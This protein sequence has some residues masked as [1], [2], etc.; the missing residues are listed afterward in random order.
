MDRSVGWF[1]HPHAYT[2]NAP[3]TPMRTLTMHQTP[4]CVHSQCTKHPHAYTHN[5]PNT[6]M[7]TLTMHQTPPC[8]QQPQTHV[9][10][11]SNTSSCPHYTTTLPPN[12]TYPP[13]QVYSIPLGGMCTRQAF[14]I[15]GSGSTYIYG[16]VD[17]TYKDKMSSEQ[18]IKFTTNGG[19]CGLEW[20]GMW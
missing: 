10:K 18:C 13:T 9:H 7:R 2:H 5:A 16:Y 11:L 4:P 8:V 19:W 14:T 20:V 6:P 3:N 1:K 15:G 12:S 17:A